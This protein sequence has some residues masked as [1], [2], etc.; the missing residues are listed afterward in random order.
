MDNKNKNSTNKNNSNSKNVNSAK[1][2]KTVEDNVGKEQDTY[3]LKNYSLGWK[4][5]PKQFNTGILI[6]RF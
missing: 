3:L 1:P 6:S 4:Q 5:K 2:L